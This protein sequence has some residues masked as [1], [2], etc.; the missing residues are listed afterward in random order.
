MNEDFS[1]EETT[2]I[3]LKIRDAIEE[4]EDRHK[5]ELKALKEQFEVVGNHLLNFCNDL[6]LDSVK[7]PVGTISRRVTSRYWTNDWNSMYQVIRDH[8]AFNL[9]E[10]RIHQGNMKQFIQEHPE[11]FP[12]GLNADR[13][14]TVQVRKPTSK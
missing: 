10:Q 11:A 3:Y 14:Y 1:L 4:M 5:E 2:R 8:D 6:N 7:T 9:L 13:K 12:P